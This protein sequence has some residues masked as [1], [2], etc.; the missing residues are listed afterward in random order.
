MGITTREL[1]SLLFEIKNQDITI[2]ELR[3]RLF[4]MDEQDEQISIENLRKI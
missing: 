2:A 1:R 4:E 3:R